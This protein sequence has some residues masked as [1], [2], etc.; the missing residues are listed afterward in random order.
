MAFLIKLMFRATAGSTLKRYRE[1]CKDP[2]GTQER[3]LQGII[4]R[5]A[6]S[7][8][9]RRH[10]FGSLK[11]LFDFQNAVPLGS[12]ESLS[13]YIQAALNGEPSQL[14]VEAPVFFA[15]TSGT[16]GPSK[17]IPV[18]KESGIRKSQLTRV[19]LSGL[20]RDH[21]TIFD[22]RILA[23]V[24]PAVESYSPSGTP[25]GSESGHGYRNMPFYLKAI[26]SCPYEVYRIKGYRSRYYALVRIAAG[27]NIRMIYA[28]NPS[29]ILLLAK[30]LGTHTEAVIR[31]VRDGTLSREFHIEDDI[32]KTIEEG[33]RPDPSRA[34]A[35]ERAAKAGG[36]VLLPRYVWPGP[37]VLCCWKG[38]SMS[39]YLQRFA[40]FFHRNTPV[41]DPG[42]LASEHRS[43]VPFADE[44]DAGALAVSTNFYEFLPWEERDSPS[45]TLLPA[46]LLESGRKY[47]VFVTTHAGLYRYDMD[48]IVEVTGHY[49]KTPLIRFIQK[50]MGVVSF[51][52]EKL[53][54]RQVV[55]AVGKAFERRTG[56]YTFITALGEFRGPVPAY[57]FLAE[58]DDPIDEREGKELLSS[59]EKE[60]RS[61]NVEYGS[62]RDSLRLGAPVLRVVRRGEYENYRK[63]QVQQGAPEGQF[64]ILRLSTD[65]KIAEQF[66][67][68]KE[69]EME[70][71]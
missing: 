11:T 8:F 40:P 28:L 35:L 37:P 71:P 29:T 20:Y 31:D 7:A 47:Y 32:R 16:T 56:R 13:P 62:K 66:A 54:E 5:N 17:Y 25:C 52:G 34:A 39:L 48:D 42:Y 53:Y 50:G 46:H 21:P 45:K 68:Q 24:S 49:E 64:K 14:T 60:L 67:F 33:L 18:T 36:G 2:G 43:S 10:R 3:L 57:V 65:K 70:E 51:T 38:G 12:Y 15:I 30:W 55:A 4:R 61:R 63:R 22:G 41:R 1:E 58:L 44:G 19:W 26:Y 23:V 59:L 6:T 9:G 69:I 27:Q